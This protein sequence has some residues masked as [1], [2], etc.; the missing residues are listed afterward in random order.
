MHL[1]T[2]LLLIL[3]ESTF[4]YKILVF[5]PRLGHSHVNFMGKIADILVEAGHNVTVF[6]PDLNPDVSNN[7]SKLAK[8]I[9]KKFPNNQ[10][11]EKSSQKNMWKKKGDSILQ[12]YRLHKR[13]ADAQRM[14]C[15]K[16]LED[17]ELMG[18]L[19]SEQYDLGITEQINFCGYAI[20]KRIGLKNHI[21]TRAINL[22]EVSSDLFG[23]SS[24]PS[25][26]PAGFSFKSDKMNYLDRLTNVIMYTITYV[27]TKL[28]WD[29]AAQSLQ[30]HLP[31][32]FDYIETMNE[33]SVVFVNTDELL[34]FSRLI[35]RKI[36]FIGGIAIPEA[37]PLTD[38]YQQLLDNSERGVILV[39]FGT[40]IKSKYMSSNEKKIFEDAFQQ[41]PEITFI[42]KYE[43]EERVE[44]VHL[45]NVIRKKWI[46]QND[47][48]NHHKL[49]AFVS[50]C[51]QNSLM[52]SIS[53][54]VP[55]ICMPFFADQFRN[56]RTAESRNV[57]LI[58]NKENLTVIGLSSA[59]KII[60]YEES[61]R[62]SAQ[63]LKKMIRYKPVS[64]RE[65]LIR[66]T[67]FAIKY[68]PFDNFNVAA[69]FIFGEKVSAQ[70]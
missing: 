38:D 19:Q 16:H 3:L 51:G 26:V 45:P 50:H 31:N 44:D 32:K 1:Y 41:L 12:V 18:L 20:F 55:L 34:E 2:I 21:T 47:L 29:S 43:D 23:V 68:G 11:F 61:Y 9:E 15:K 37:S 24:N 36:V 28:I 25:Y 46:P 69:F 42:W 64:A 67:E 56:S 48:L 53:A 54:G 59:L 58:L 63:K 49:L 10:Y 70:K 8:I 52:E 33:S 4:S 60:I 30:H 66:Y 14:T 13:L 35:S 40:M 62:K 39:S 65:R 57:A 6:V 17:N 7:G 27:L 5:S 22:L